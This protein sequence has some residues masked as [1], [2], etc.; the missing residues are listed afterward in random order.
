MISTPLCPELGM[1]WEPADTGCVFMGLTTWWVD[2]HAKE[3]L[4]VID[5]VRRASGC[6]GKAVMSITWGSSAFIHSLIHFIPSITTW[7]SQMVL[8]IKNPPVNAGDI[9][10]EGSIPRSGRLPG[11]GQ[12]N[13]FQYSC[14]ENP[15]DRGAW[16][17]IVHRVTKSQTQ[18][19]QLSVQ[20][21]MN[22][23]RDFLRR[24]SGTSRRG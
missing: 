9:R 17:A 5:T 6:W 7:A 16:R 24:M 2:R 13:P 8:V 11:G 10:N 19:K 18:L 1:Y 15:V 4:W 20:A 22:L 23:R 21:W 3:N 12:G 14:L